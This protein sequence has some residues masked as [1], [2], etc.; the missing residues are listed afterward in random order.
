[1][2]QVREL[3]KNK[4]GEIF[5]VSPD[6]TVYDALMLMAEKEI[7]AVLVMQGDIL[8]GILSERDYARKVVLFGKTS[9]ELKVH[10]IM[11]DKVYFVEGDHP[12]SDCIALMTEK[13]IR[14]LPVFESGKLLGVISIGDVLK[15]ILQ[16]KEFVISQ[17]EHFIQGGSFHG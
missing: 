17:L 7:G 15:S 6:T 14:H 3:L 12:V 9:K 5:R 1:M 2:Q 13:R 10:E 16:E 8:A 11:T 4:S